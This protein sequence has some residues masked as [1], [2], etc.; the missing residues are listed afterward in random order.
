MKEPLEMK[1]NPKARRTPPWLILSNNFEVRPT[2]L[3]EMTAPREIIPGR[4]Y[5]VTR[6][7][8][9]RQF[10]LRP[11]RATNQ[12]FKYCLLVASKRF[13]ILVHGFVVLSNHYHLVLTD[14]HGNLPMFMGWLN[15]HVAKSINALLGRWENLFDNGK[16]SAV[17]LEDEGAVRD[18]LAYTLANPVDAG[19]VK[20]A[21]RW[22][23]CWSH[24][25]RIDGA[26]M[27]VARPKGFFRKSGTMPAETSLQLTRPP[28]FEDMSSKAFRKMLNDDLAERESAAR[29]RMAKEGRVFLGVLG[30][31]AQ[32]PFDRPKT[33]EPRRSLNP[34]IA[35]RDKWK[36]V[37]AIGRRKV[38]LSRYRQAFT[39]WREGKTE[40]VFPAGTYWMRHF[41]AACCAGQLDR[42]ARATSLP[43]PQF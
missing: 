18:K 40:V 41:T 7:C 43:P 32:S 9:Q 14:I 29:T 19:L 5:M 39:A 22:P 27:R 8:T 3:I 16:Y 13:G 34:R 1:K 6:R 12:V 42:Q 28:C 15:K 21:R 30:V 24:P 10:L 20:K 33:H 38:F 4:T 37:E 26:P 17:V 11:S 31:R 2:T 35:C 25:S 36:R 23:G